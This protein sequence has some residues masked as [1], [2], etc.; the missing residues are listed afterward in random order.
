[1]DS[2]VLELPSLDEIGNDEDEYHHHMSPSQN[3]LH[4]FEMPDPERPYQ[5][6]CGATRTPHPN[7]LEL[8][9][10]PECSRIRGKPCLLEQQGD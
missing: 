1:M 2:D 3:Q 6:L 8:P 5:A 9:C 4:P 10:C 7:P